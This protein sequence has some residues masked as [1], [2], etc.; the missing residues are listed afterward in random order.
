MKYTWNSKIFNKIQTAE[1][2]ESSEMAFNIHLV[3]L[4]FLT[5]LCWF[6]K[7]V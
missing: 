2:Q 3:K 7:N 6:Y 4:T 1:G 5:F